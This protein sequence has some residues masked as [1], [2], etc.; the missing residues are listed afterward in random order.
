MVMAEHQRTAIA[1]LKRIAECLSKEVETWL[2][3]MKALRK[4]RANEEASLKK[5][6]QKIQ[7]EVERA[8]RRE[9]EKQEKEEAR[10]RKL[11]Q[12]AQTREREEEQPCLP[13][14]RRRTGGIAEL[15][16]DDPTILRE[17]S[18]FSGG[19]MVF[20][21]ELSDFVRRI[22]Q[23]PETSCGARLKKAPLRKAMNAT[24]PTI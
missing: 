8:A 22:C 13:K 12:D 20:F 10:L 21:S 14:K 16:E 23:F 17:M 6:E 7:Q 3:S 5:A 1:V 15:T 24:Q 2:A 19:S 18:K 11:E 9:R 4:A